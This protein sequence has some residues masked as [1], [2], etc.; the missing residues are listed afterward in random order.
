MSNAAERVELRGDG[1]YCRADRLPHK[2]ARSLRLRTA[3]K[4]RESSIAAKVRNIRK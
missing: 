4:A 1:E 2:R 3:T